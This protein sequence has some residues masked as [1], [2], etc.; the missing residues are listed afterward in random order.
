MAQLRTRP[1][2]RLTNGLAYGCGGKHRNHEPAAMVSE[3]TYSR[4]MTRLV[5]GKETK[6]FTVPRGAEVQ[7]YAFSDN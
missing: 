1:D 5:A 4:D 6:V 7:G 2:S 3:V